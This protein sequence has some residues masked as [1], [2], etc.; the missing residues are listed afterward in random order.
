[1]S[2]DSILNDDSGNVGEILVEERRGA[3][4]TLRE[5]DARETR[6]ASMEVAN[7]AL[8]GAL[9]VM[10]RMLQVTMVAL[11]LLFIATGYQSVQENQRGV[12]VSLGRVTATDLSPGPHFTLP[13]PFGEVITVDTRP[14]NIEL[15]T[16]FFP[17]LTDAEKVR[18]FES[19]SN[20]REL[21]PKRDGSMLTA[22]RSLAHA[23]WSFRY[24]RSNPEQYLRTL[25]P[26]DEDKF[27]RFAVERAI[28]RV[29]AEVT[30]DDLQRADE[31]QAVFDQVR[32]AAQSMLDAVT[33]GLTLIDVT[34]QR[35]YP[36]TR[37]LRTFTQSNTAVS[38][39]EAGKEKAQAEANAILIS[40]AGAAARPL[41][42]L[43]ESYERAVDDGD[44]EG[45]EQILTTVFALLDGDY[46]DGGLI[47]DGQD[48]GRTAV[49]GDV[50]VRL[51]AARAYRQKVANE[52]RSR[53]EVFSA[54]LPT[55]LRNPRLF[56]ASER[57]RAMQEMSRKQLL[58]V[59]MIPGNTDGFQITINDDPEVLRDV[60]SKERSDRRKM[61]EKARQD[62]IK[63]RR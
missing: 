27:V 48:V 28:V 23:K 62:M 46:A 47:I 8:A 57:A 5:D 13:R 40:T 17:F 3:S 6:A 44:E 59:F 34:A 32:L 30:L 58:K 26:D 31:R 16:A 56:M 20:K 36:P 15:D 41:L 1:M 19:V 21:D 29:I 45:A 35:F 49:A 43:I 37:V 61:A 14:V 53:A 60:E 11:L 55:Y 52:A 25:H 63:G 2:D 12:K 18:S 39:A 51:S 4:L 7:Q 24:T 10:Y 42:A 38:V 22:D 33:S 54:K 50:S 9:R